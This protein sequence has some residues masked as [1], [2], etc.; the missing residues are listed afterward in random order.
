MESSANVIERKG[1]KM[2]FM[3]SIKEKM[4]FEFLFISIKQMNYEI[5][6]YKKQKNNAM[7]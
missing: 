5:D 3:S 1:E 6:E 2:K 4:K 7:I